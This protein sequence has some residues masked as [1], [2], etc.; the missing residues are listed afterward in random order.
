MRTQPIHFMCSTLA[1]LVLASAAA[2]A[3]GFDPT[4]IPPQQ[5]SPSQRYSGSVPIDMT[6]GV[7][8]NNGTFG[9]PNAEFEEWAKAPV[10]ALGMSA[11]T[12]PYQDKNSFVRAMREN[13]N[14]IEAAISNWSTSANETKPE[15]IDYSKN[16]MEKLKPLLE[17]AR[18]TMKEANRAG[19]SSWEDAQANARKAILTLRGTYTELHKNVV[20]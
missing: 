19:E 1:T 9:L 3:S 15:A 5:L 7:W 12:Y 4:Q 14:F 10:V 20:R 6:H 8:F 2:N 11:L 13:I 18:E 17:S 16:A